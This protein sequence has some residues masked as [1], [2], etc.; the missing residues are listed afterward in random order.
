MAKLSALKDYQSPWLKPEDLMGKPRRVRIADYEVTEMKQQDNTKQ[1]KI[2]LSFMHKDKKLILN[3]SNAAALGQALGDDLDDW[4][5]AEIILTPGQA[6]NGQPTILCTA[7]PVEPQAP[8]ANQAPVVASS[9][10]DP[11]IPF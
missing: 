5:G 7:I 1:T 8:V 10:A 2:I 6:Q 4:T 9:R 11:D 3:R